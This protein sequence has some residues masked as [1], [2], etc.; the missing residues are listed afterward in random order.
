MKNKTA[1][2]LDTSECFKWKNE[3]TLRMT[4]SQ[5]AHYQKALCINIE[6]ESEVVNP[7]LEDCIDLDP[8]YGSWYGGFIKDGKSFP[9]GQRDVPY[10]SYLPGQ[11]FGHLV[12]KFWLS[13]RGMAVVA[14]DDFPLYLRV[15]TTD[16]GRLCLSS[17]YGHQDLY[18]NQTRKLSYSICRTESYKD[19]HN[20]VMDKFYS[21]GSIQNRTIDPLLLSQ[22]V[23]TTS[24]GNIKTF[25]AK[26]EEK[27]LNS[28]GYVL[29]SHDNRLVEVLSGIGTIESSREGFQ[30][31]PHIPLTV[32]LDHLSTDLWIE[33]IDMNVPRLFKGKSSAYAMLNPASQYTQSL[34]QDTLAN[35]SNLV[36]INNLTIGEVSGQE[37]YPNQENTQTFQP[38]VRN[39]VDSVLA[40]STG[41]VM[42]SEAS[43][44]QSSSVIYQLPASDNIADI[45]LKVLHSSVMGYNVISTSAISAETFSK[46]EVIRLMQLSIFLPITQFSESVLD[47][48]DDPVVKQMWE[49]CLETRDFLNIESMIKKHLLSSPTAPLYTPIWWENSIT[50]NANLRRHTEFMF[51]DYFLVVPIVDVNR[52]S[53]IVYFPDKNTSWYWTDHKLSN[54]PSPYAKKAYKGGDTEEFTDLQPHD[55]LVFERI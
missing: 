28:S 30:I 8:L 42:T 35:T 38:Y 54:S 21:S 17:W 47:Y 2:N 53:R 11:S 16:P 15:D 14:S 52:T 44:M 6:W 20:L 18:I 40:A 24:S 33:S 31:S 46:D 5:P 26:L 7:I 23:F 29:N 45:V 22:P 3:S 49:G 10:G 39:F 55:L 27:G 43:G 37:F 48:F 51:A 4:R 41:S 32:A 36:L 1:E 25:R 12:E 34:I 9:V 19:T 13:T 50:N